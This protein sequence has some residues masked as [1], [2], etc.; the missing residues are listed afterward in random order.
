MRTL[1]GKE[2]E[3]DRKGN[4]EIYF[5]TCI[6]IFWMNWLHLFQFDVTFTFLSLQGK[7]GQGSGGHEQV[8]VHLGQENVPQQDSK[9]KG[10]LGMR[11]F[12]WVE[13]LRNRKLV[14]LLHWCNRTT[15]FQFL[16]FQQGNG[17][18]EPWTSWRHFLDRVFNILNN[19]M[20]CCNRFLLNF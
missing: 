18:I 7:D 15:G 8:S 2:K 5:L 20:C 13:I 6:L 3:S 19:F 10:C 9:K 1:K 16:N 11:S 17:K 4:F 14:I 12:S